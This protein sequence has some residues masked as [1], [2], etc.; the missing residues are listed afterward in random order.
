MPKEM[1]GKSRR[2]FLK[3][4]AAAICAA[5]ISR[6]AFSPSPLASAADSAL[7]APDGLSIKKGLVLSMLPSKLPIADRFKLARDT[8]FE[9]IQAPTTSDTNHADE[10]KAAADSSGVRV[11]SVMNMDHWMYPL[12]SSDPS[13]VETSLKGMRTSLHNAKLWGSDAVLLVPAVVD[14]QTS[15][16][17][18]WTRSQAQIRSLLPLAEELKI[19]IAIEEVWNKFLLSPLE[20]VTYISEFK[21]PL[22]RAWFDVGNVVLYGYPQDWIHTLGSSIFKVHLK[23][24]RRKE[25]GYAWVNLGDGDIDWPAVRQA[26]AD[27]GY[28][29]SA[30]AELEPGDEPYLRD[31]SRRIDH[32]LL[33]KS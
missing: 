16:K 24:F 9:V 11:D 3:S 26:F 6:N 22:I 18:A 5:R 15:Y 7:P 21:T 25:D 4:S 14:P 2:D 23:D 12:S 17:D 32:L 20:M 29:G 8:G 30:I 33:G 19:V 10:I 28:R 31:V 27:V 1:P 13:V